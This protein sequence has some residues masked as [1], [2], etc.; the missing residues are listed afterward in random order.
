MALFAAHLVNR[1]ATNRRTWGYQRAEI[2]AAAL[3]ALLLLGVGVYVFIESIRRLIE[4]PE[5]A[6]VGM[7]AF[8]IVGLLGNAIGITLLASRRRANLNLPA[9][10]LEVLSDALGSVAV[11]AGAIVIA[12]TGWTRADAV[13]S[14]FIVIL[15]LLR[16][17]A[18]LRDTA[19]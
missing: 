1:P 17:F 7:L 16:T 13:V 14:L 18:L 19:R 6:T 4:P 2:L 3:Q 12:V 15:I 8:G 11:I 5:I 10:F 9:A